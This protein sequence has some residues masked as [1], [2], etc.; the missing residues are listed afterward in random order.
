MGTDIFEIKDEEKFKQG[1][2]YA[3]NEKMFR[4]EKV[5]REL[6]QAKDTNK[7]DDF[8]KGVNAILNTLPIGRRIFI[9]IIEDYIGHCNDLEYEG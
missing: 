8:Y 2:S 6:K 1:I 3:I 4:K 9:E 5:E 7:Y